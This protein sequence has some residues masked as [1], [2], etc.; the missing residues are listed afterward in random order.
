MAS[1]S[2]ESELETGYVPQSGI[3]NYSLVRKGEK[4]GKCL[5][6][7]GEGTQTEA[8]TEG[9]RGVG[10]DCRTNPHSFRLLELL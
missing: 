3:L 8:E 6:G 4:L 5:F 9:E 1:R 2:P 7:R 10:T